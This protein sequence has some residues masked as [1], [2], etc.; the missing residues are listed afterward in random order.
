MSWKVHAIG[1]CSLL[2]T[3]DILHPKS[4]HYHRLKLQSALQTHCMWVSSTSQILEE[5]GRSLQHGEMDKAFPSSRE[6]Y[7]TTGRGSSAVVK[8][9]KAKGENQLY[10]MISFSKLSHTLWV[11][12]K[13]LLWRFEWM[14]SKISFPHREFGMKNNLSIKDNANAVSVSEHEV[15]NTGWSWWCVIPSD[16]FLTNNKISMI[17]TVAT[18]QS[19][20]LIRQFFEGIR[21]RDVKPALSWQTQI[22]LS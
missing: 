21:G 15:E 13:V 16:S 11:L 4:L 9:W 18:L 10:S 5:S 12:F 2:L 20:V 1:I 14:A 22:W 8:V 6:L 17:P 3:P 19:C 7:V